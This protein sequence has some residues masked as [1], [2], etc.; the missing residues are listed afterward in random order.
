VNYFTKQLKSS[1]VYF[2]VAKSLQRN[3]Q[4]LKITFL[5]DLVVI[6]KCLLSKTSSRKNISDLIKPALPSQV[7]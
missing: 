1:L 4:S 5:T 3:T 7:F 6:Q 2:R